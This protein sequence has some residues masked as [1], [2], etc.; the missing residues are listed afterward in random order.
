MLIS[1]INN[2]QL[3]K[4]K[5]TIMTSTSKVIRS[6]N[7][8]KSEATA[9]AEYD[10]YIGLDWS[11]RTMAIARMTKHQSFPVTNERPTDL[12]E[13]KLYLDQLRGTRVLVVEETTTAHWLYLELCEHV[14]RII[15]CD[16]YRNKLLSEGAKTDKIDAAKLCQLLKAGLLK[17]VF[18]TH[19]KDYELRKLVS[20]YRDLVQSGVRLKNQRSALFRAEGKH[21]SEQLKNTTLHFIL[22]RIDQEIA[23]YEQ[24]KADYVERFAHV[25]KTDK[26]VRLQSTIPGIGIIGAVKIVAV[27]VDARRFDHTGKYLSYCGLV[28]LHK[29]SGQRSYGL[30]HP[31]C[32]R[33]LKSVYKTAALGALTHKGE[34]NEYY[35]SLRARGVAEHNARNTIARHIAKV[36]YGMLKHGTSYQSYLWKERMLSATKKQA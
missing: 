10:H 28:M 31:R 19:S 32:D 23:H 20:A 29:M 1:S 21:C 18:H 2:W 9:R 7:K 30:R 34:M 3:I 6:D 33:E 15:I 11:E 12:K 4:G 14:E 25:A 36:S 27:V 22:E 13:M 5:E 26:R 16:P 17:E 35:E 8:S 24:M